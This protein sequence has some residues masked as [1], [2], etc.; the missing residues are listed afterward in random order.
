M[1]PLSFFMSR[2]FLLVWFVAGA[3]AAQA[4]VKVYGTAAMGGANGHG[5]LFSV[6]SDG[7]HP[8]VLH[9]FAGPGDGYEPGGSVISDTSSKLYGVT[10]VGG[11]EGTG[12]IYSYDTATHVYQKIFDFTDSAGKGFY[13]TNNFTLYQHKLYGLTGHGGANNT[14]TLYSFDPATGA[15]TDVFDLPDRGVSFYIGAYTAPTF[16]NGKIYFNTSNGGVNNQGMLAEVDLATGTFTDLHDFPNN[17]FEYPDL[18][19]IVIDSILYNVSV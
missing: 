4:Q 12:T 15:V 5:T 19:P 17:T 1:Q 7:S 6:Y 18:S 9:S 11:I 10:R 2:T 13:P 3:A 14:G 8:E 16:L